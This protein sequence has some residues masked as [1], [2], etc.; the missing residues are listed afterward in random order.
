MGIGNRHQVQIVPYTDTQGA[1]GNWTGGTE[2]APVDVWAEVQN[3]SGFRAY[4]NGQT[5]IGQ[6]KDFFIR[7]RFDQFPN[8]NW[9]IVYDGRRW[10]V[11]EIR[12]QDEKK[13]YYRL[14]ASSKSNV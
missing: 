13:F 4:Q 1:A 5:Q 6:T 14:T 2:G 11:S 9:R 3:P 7:F 8:A 10:T 12:K